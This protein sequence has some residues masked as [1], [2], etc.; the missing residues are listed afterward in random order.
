MERDDDGEPELAE[1]LERAER[2]EG[3]LRP[4]QMD[5]IHLCEVRTQGAHGDA[6]SA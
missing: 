6:E 5:E 1:L 3:V 2:E 4:V